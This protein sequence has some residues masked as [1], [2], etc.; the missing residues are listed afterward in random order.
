MTEERVPDPRLLVFREVLPGDVRKQRAESN[1][2]ATGGGARD[3]RFRHGDEMSP[4]LTRM[5]PSP[6][7]EEGVTRGNVCWVDSDRRVQTAEIEF[8]RPT[9]ARPNEVRLGCIYN[10]LSWNVD[11]AAYQESQRNG[12]RWFYYLVL[13]GRGRVWARLFRQ[14]HLANENPLVRDYVRQRIADTPG[15]RAIFGSIDLITGETC[16]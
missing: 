14:E 16:P 6:A 2:S 15:N 10:V 8:W 7:D 1:D 3:L 4:I 9:D 12:Q 5:F 13:D 11:D